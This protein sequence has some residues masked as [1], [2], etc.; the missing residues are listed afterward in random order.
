MGT[1][2]DC[3]EPVRWFRRPEDMDKWMPPLEWAGH[4][5]IVVDGGESGEQAATEVSIYR[6]HHCD[7]EKMAAWQEY[8]AKLEEVRQRGQAVE[9]N[10]KSAKLVAQ[11]PKDWE[12][13]RDR[14]QQ[15]ARLEAMVVECNKCQVKAGVPCYN[16]TIFKKTGE[17]VPTKM[18]HTSRWMEALKHLGRTPYEQ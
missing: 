12:I 1:H 6:P 5:Y 13:A 9:L 4:A 16:L 11:K 18:P 8:K 17:Q 10:G 15:T 7:P 3:G 14:N 2:K